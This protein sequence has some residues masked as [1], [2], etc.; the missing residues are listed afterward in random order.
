L[1]AALR[2]ADP[3]LAV[4][5]HLQRQGQWLLIA[6]Q[7]YDLS[8]LRRVWLVG[9]GKASVAMA[10]AAAQVLGERLSGGL[11]IVKEG[12]E[13]S[14]WAEPD[15]KQ[16][17]QGKV[18]ILPAAHPIPDARSLAAAQRLRQFLQGVQETD[19]VL[20]LLSGGGSALLTDPV[21]GVSL[22]DLQSLTR[23]LLSCGATI[24]EINCLRKHLERLKGGRLAQSVGSA[25]ACLI[26]SDVVG[27]SLEVI[28]SGPTVADPTTFEDAWAV[29]E[30]HRLLEQVPPGVRH[31][32]A[33][34]RQGKVPETPK[35]GD[36]CFER[37]Q[38]VIIAGNRHAA[39]AAVLQAQREGFNAL[40]LTT[41]LQGE[42]RQAGRFLAAL[43][44]QVVA[45]GQPLPRPACLVAGGETTVT[46]QGDGL[47]GRNQELALGAVQ[48]LDGLPGVALVT[49][50]TDG[51]DGPTEAAGAV[52]T[53]ETLVRARAMGLDAE[54]FLRR[55]DSYNFFKPLGDLL[56]S[57]P[58]GT[59]VNDL[60]LVLAFQ[61]W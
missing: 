35:A 37:V 32:L 8:T 12:Y 31:Y 40:L 25:L 50:A 27:D 49:L 20:C 29:L 6:G 47:G 21:E 18:D 46:L 42:A 36:V 30:R 11:V 7:P 22:T 52:A 5:R 59:N 41:F 55:N 34:G 9:V 10:H 15:E 57:G 38:N 14:P 3:A 16:A 45:S 60:A 26:L 51:G 56:I 1:E 23:L 61:P 44:R 2:A 43:A 33:L 53:G 48:D 19:L 28:A 39:E 54:H 17:L 24:H 58:T 13:S 4:R